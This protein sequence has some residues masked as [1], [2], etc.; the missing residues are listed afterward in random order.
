MIASGLYLIKERTQG[1][2][3][4]IGN[5]ARATRQAEQPRRAGLNQG[6]HSKLCTHIAQVQTHM[7]E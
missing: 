7:N 1:K 2:A 4:Q 5:H 6:E 3:Q